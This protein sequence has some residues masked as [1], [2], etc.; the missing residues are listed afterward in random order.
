M[1]A[2]TLAQQR[3]FLFF[4][5]LWGHSAWCL[6]DSR[7]ELFEFRRVDGEKWPAY[8]RLTA[9]KSHCF[10]AGKRWPIG[11]LESAPF[12]RVAWVEGAPDFLA[13]FHFLLL[14]GKSEHVAPVGVLGA[15]NHALA[16]DGLA[17]FTGK[18]ICLFPHVDD[19]GRAAM[20]VWARQLKDAGALRVSAFDLS[21][22]VLVD[23]T[24]GKDLA[25]VA[26]IGVECFEREQK[27]QEVLP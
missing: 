20:R 15:S 13:L 3:G 14:E 24:E 21:R 19:A 11:T 27:F 8:G 12:S 18:S 16:P 26:R 9:R 6:T 23:G 25:D 17:H 1:D 2:L 5:N 4:A 22:L 10:G 7:R